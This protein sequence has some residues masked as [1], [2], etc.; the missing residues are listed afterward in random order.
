MPAAPL[1]AVSGLGWEAGVA[2]T[3]NLLLTIELPSEHGEGGV[4][5]STTKT[6][7]EMEC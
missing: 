5:D 2:L 1:S 7:D 4:V 6:K 3:A